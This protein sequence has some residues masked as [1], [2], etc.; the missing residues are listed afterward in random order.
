MSPLFCSRPAE[1]SYICF[2]SYLS[3]IP[4][5]NTNRTKKEIDL[6]KSNVY[7]SFLFSLTRLKVWIG[8]SNFCICSFC[9]VHVN[10]NI[11]NLKSICYLLRTLEKNWFML[12]V[13]KTL[14]VFNRLRKKISVALG[15]G[16]NVLNTLSSFLTSNLIK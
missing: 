13:T 8:K 10:Y 16:Q 14:F 1:F 9:R 5:I 4:I 11:E 2:Y 6:L 3:F 15:Y 12:R 7:F